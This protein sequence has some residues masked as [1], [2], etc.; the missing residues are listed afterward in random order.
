M[1]GE[2]KHADLGETDD[3]RAYQKTIRVR[4]IGQTDLFGIFRIFN[5]YLLSVRR[6]H[7]RADQD[8]HFQFCQIQSREIYQT[9]FCRKFGLRLLNARKP[10]LNGQLLC[11]KAEILLKTGKN[12]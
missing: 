10:L 7:P 5:G 1:K 9:G 11:K 2:V 4:K 6:P 12:H 8:A 3:G